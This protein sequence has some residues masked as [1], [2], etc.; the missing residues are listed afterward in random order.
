MRALN[1]RNRFRSQLFILLK[2][3]LWLVHNG[4]AGRSQ[5]GL[6]LTHNP[7]ILRDDIRRC[8]CR[9]Q[10]RTDNRHQQACRVIG[11]GGSV[12]IQLVVGSCSWAWRSDWLIIGVL[13][14][15]GHVSD[16]RWGRQTAQIVVGRWP[17]YM[18]RL[19]YTWTVIVFCSSF[20][21]CSLDYWWY[22]CC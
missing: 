6:C 1:L 9:C 10:G 20:L 16:T 14:A 4:R 21:N 18:V 19:T 15:E 2:Q 3:W 8:C 22:C 17:T 7:I 12:A 5:F 11:P 13:F